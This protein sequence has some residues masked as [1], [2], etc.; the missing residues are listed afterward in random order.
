MQEVEIISLEASKCPAQDENMMCESVSLHIY[1]ITPIESCWL[2]VLI[3][4]F[5]FCDFEADCCYV[6]KVFV[7]LLHFLNRNACDFM[8][9]ICYFCYPYV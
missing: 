6:L 9:V 2:H 3:R 7:V 8:D 4:I 5:F 1:M